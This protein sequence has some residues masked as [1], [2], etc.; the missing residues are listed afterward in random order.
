MH[1]FNMSLCFI[2]IFLDWRLGFE[3]TLQ[4]RGWNLRALQNETHTRASIFNKFCCS[5]TRCKIYERSMWR[6]FMGR[7]VSYRSSQSHSLLDL[8]WCFHYEHIVRPHYD[9]CY[10]GV[11]S[12]PKSC[13]T[14]GKYRCIVK[15]SDHIRSTHFKWAQPTP[16]RSFFFYLIWYDKKN[17]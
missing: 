13:N 4:L 17:L 12:W 5:Q 14:Q 2:S 15:K 1:E 7:N 16:Y 9:M 11:H 6:F 10:C 8:K 3:P